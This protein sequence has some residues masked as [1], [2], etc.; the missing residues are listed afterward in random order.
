MRVALTPAEG[1]GWRAIGPKAIVKANLPTATPVGRFF[2]CHPAWKSPLVRSFAG[3]SSMMLRQ[4]LCAAALYALPGLPA[5]GDSLERSFVFHREHVLGT[6]LEVQVEA[7]DEA[8]ARAAE[9]AAFAEIGRLS[10]IFSGY[11]PQSELSRW[12]AQPGKSLVLS[13]ELREV[14]RA[15]ET[16]TAVSGGAFH[17]GVE[18]LSKLWREAAVTGAVPSRQSMER[19]LAILAEP[20][21]RFDESL[22]DSASWHGRGEIS[23]NGIAKGAIVD[24]ACEVAAARPGVTG[25]LVSI[26]GDMR[27][28]G[29]LMRTVG[30][31]DPASDAENARP[32]RTVRL[33]GE[34]LA[35]SGRYR[36]GFLVGNVWHSHILDP[37][38]GQP[39]RGIA[40]STVIAR[41]AADADALATICSVLSP[42]ESLE[43]IDSIE[44]AR[45]LLVKE[46]GTVIESRRW[47][48]LERAESTVN[49]T[50][51]QL[52][53]ADPPADS[54]GK[55]GTATGD[56][57]GAGKK[58]PKL[59]EL[60][61]RFE[62]TKAERYDYYRPY[63][64]IWLENEAGKPVRTALLWLATKQPGPQWHRELIR[65]YRNDQERLKA[66]ELQLIGTVSGATRGPGEYK[67]VFDGLDD[68]GNPL[69]PGKYTLFLE[70]SRE[71]GTYQLIRKPL[72][73]KSEAI[74]LTK[75]KGNVEIPAAS[76]EY[77]ARNQ[78]LR[79]DP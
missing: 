54:S 71:H 47:N 69:E 11:D 43:L 37:R 52:A 3:R 44:G 14:L 10:K 18:G 68:H 36:R 30:I 17:P 2:P 23:L 65:W 77:R 20:Q 50:D 61:V 73:L 78:D 72:E 55:D 66:D 26:G 49:D 24:H 70:A 12:L 27:A 19:E 39:A 62:L 58:P 5:W 41:T 21:W 29:S 6:S 31:V 63:V 56:E 57:Q 42:A 16:W 75:L 4:I 8:V 53:A 74:P 34:G 59:L 1:G 40:A 35:T 79:R 28:C 15:C 45:C 22:A 67:A 76:Y 9:Q 48:R 51:S 32:L 64:A 46:D 33:Q 25:V 60:T 38:T 7:A 13:R